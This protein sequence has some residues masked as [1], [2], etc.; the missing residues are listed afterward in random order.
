M[1]W[2]AYGDLEGGAIALLLLN[3]PYFCLLIESLPRTGTSTPTS[4]EESNIF[5]G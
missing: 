3:Q 1:I 2:G 4:G 5:P